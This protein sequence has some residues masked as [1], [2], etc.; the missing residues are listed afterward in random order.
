MRKCNK[1]EREGREENQVKKVGQKLQLRLA[2]E[3]KGGERKQ[4]L[5][6]HKQSEVRGQRE[7]GVRKYR[8]KWRE[9]IYKKVRER[10]E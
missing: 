3:R 1:K 5:K 8:Q 2:M 4:S 10:V 7:R 6:V 9:T